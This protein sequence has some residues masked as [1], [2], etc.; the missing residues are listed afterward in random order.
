MNKYIEIPLALIRP[1]P[2]QPRREFDAEALASLADSLRQHGLLQPIEV[3]ED[4][5]GAYILHHGERRLRAAAL[6]GLS[7]I[8]AVVV[9]ALNEEQRLTRAL[10]ENL[11]RED[12]NPIDEALAYRKLLVWFRTPS[13]IADIVGRAE[14]TINGRLM[15]LDLPAEVQQLI[16]DSRFPRDARVARAVLNLPVDMQAPFARLCANQ[17]LQVP[18]IV[19]S[20]QRVLAKLDNRNGQ[21][22]KHTYADRQPLDTEAPALALVYG[23]GGK[24]KLLPEAYQPAVEGTCRACP[25]FTAMKEHRPCADCPLT[26]FV[27][28]MTNTAQVIA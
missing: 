14:P 19:A 21:A 27:R 25:W 26:I 7:T 24:A 20:A 12:M 1:N 16:A 11:Q 10:V 6:A 2:Q 9:P 18:A 28:N 22:L 8:R 17:K 13:R 15:L 3:E 4:G 5:A 23:S